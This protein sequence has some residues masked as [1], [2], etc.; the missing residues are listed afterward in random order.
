[1]KLSEFNQKKIYFYPVLFL[2]R[3][4]PRSIRRA[5]LSFNK[6]LLYLFLTALFLGKFYDQHVPILVNFL[7]LTIILMII[8]L[9]TLLI[10][11]FFR[12]YYYTGI[13]K[14]ELDA[15][16]VIYQAKKG[17]LIQSIFSLPIGEKLILRLG[18][19]KLEL[20]GFLSQR[21]ETIFD[22]DLPELNSQ[23][24]FT[25]KIYFL[26]LTFLDNFK[27]ELRKIIRGFRFIRNKFLLIFCIQ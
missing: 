27:F 6:Y 22:Y 19:R 23:N 5:I 26:S 7:G 17:D 21:K 12:S 25:T 4:F 18:I 14:A 1:M 15:G 11:A 9:L 2:E 20:D 13:T 24:F 8:S 3:I 10:E 16:R